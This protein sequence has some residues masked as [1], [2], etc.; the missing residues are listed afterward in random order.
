[1][2]KDEEKNKLIDNISRLLKLK[3][4]FYSKG[5]TITTYIEK[6]HQIAV[7][8]SGYADLVRY[9]IN[10]EKVIVEDFTSNDLFGEFFY[11]VNSNNE[12]NVIA[13]S[14]CEVIFFTYEDL[15][16]SSNARGQNYYEVVKDLMQ[17]ISNKIVV[18][19]TRIEILSKRTIREKLLSYFQSIANQK[20][21]R[22]F[23]LDFSLSDLADFLSI[24]RSAMMREIKNL[25][26]D[27]I[28]EKNKKKIKLVEH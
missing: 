18:M 23:Y 27:G 12:L 6:R 2:V 17:Q 9:D 3:S 21:S 1:M 25:I 28:I 13:R 5:E 11:S 8:V 22:V 4:S 24:D 7:L 26:E 16:N 19:N 20:H 14:D 15:F 10:G